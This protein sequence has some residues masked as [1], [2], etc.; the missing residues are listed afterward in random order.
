MRIPYEGNV[1]KIL[2]FHAN[3]SCAVILWEKR[4][5]L[6]EYMDHIPCAFLEEPP[7][8]EIKEFIKECKHSIK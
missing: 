4:G 7:L 6:T 3:K 5:N 8:K 1:L 2:R